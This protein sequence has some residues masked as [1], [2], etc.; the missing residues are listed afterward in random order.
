MLGLDLLLRLPADPRALFTTRAIRLFA[1]GL[2]GVLLVLFV[3]ALGV[4]DTLIG[5]FLTATLVGDALVSLVVT[6][7]ADRLGRRR[8]L[9]L[10]SLLMAGAGLGFALV[11]ASDG[12]VMWAVT[13]TLLGIVGVISPSG[14][15]CGPFMALEQSIL[16]NHIA[17]AARSLLFAWYNLIGY[18]ATAFGS[19]IAGAAVVL[20]SG[21]SVNIFQTL[22]LVA[23]FAE[24]PVAVLLGMGSRSAPLSSRNQT[25]EGFT[26]LEAYR[27]VVSAYGILG[28]ILAVRFARLSEAVEPRRISENANVGAATSSSPRSPIHNAPASGNNERA[29]LLP[30][31]QPPSLP[32][33]TSFGIRSILPGL[34]LSPESRWI[35]FKLCALFTLDSF[36]G[37]VVT[38]SILVYWFKSRFG[39]D[40]AYLGQ[41]LFVSNILAG[42]SSLAAGW[43]ST[44]V[45]LV[46][47]MV[48]THLPSNVLMIMVPLM[49]NLFWS[50]IVLFLRYSISQ[51]D[52]GP[53]QA[54][55]ASVTPAHE[56]TAVI[57]LTNIV[58][59]LGSAL[60]PLLA[61]VLVEKGYFDA[62]FF[63]CGGGKIVYDLLLLWSFGGAAREAAALRRGE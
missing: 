56:R 9:V 28:L 61:G 15:E 41:I 57:G 23:S 7:V 1:Y 18:V 59:S 43:I 49:P 5:L 6:G 31:Q 42:M 48:F 19:L 22:L 12:S 13:L 32:Q 35:T 14:N 38:G 4:T 54:Y 55:V 27:Y 40:E 62:C 30:S 11:P 2:I 47:T 33:R 16:S 46:N 63:V 25:E 53:R 26:K 37:S 60:G 51:M 29:P 8:M 10:G 21:D 39:V 3:K 34:D 58:K 24:S 44:R 20:I 36:A 45:G 50:T 52:V 17:P